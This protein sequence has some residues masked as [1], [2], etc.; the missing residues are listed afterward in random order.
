MDKTLRF[1]RTI[2][3]G[4]VFLLFFQLVADFVETIYTF[5][6]LNTNVPPEIVCVLLFFSPLALLIFRRGLPRGAELGL[7]ALAGLTRAAEV[8]L[9]KSGKMI[10]S[11]LGTGLLLV[12]L[13][14]WLARP[15]AEEGVDDDGAALE[16]GVGVA[17]ALAFSIL[18][19]GLGQG[20]DLSL[21]YPWLSWVEVG[22]LYFLAFRLASR[23]VVA[24]VEPARKEG[25]G[26]FG[27]AAALGVGVLGGLMV[28]FFAFTSPGVLARWSELDNRMILGVLAAA[29]LVYLIALKTGWLA[30]LTRPALWASNLLFVLAGTAGILI[31]QVPFPA[32]SAV[33]PVDQP[34]LILIQQIPL[35]AMIL[36]SPVVLVDLLALAREAKARRFSPRAMA[37]G[38]AIG[39]LFFL[40]IVLAQ[41]F[42]TVYDYIPV[43]GP[44]FRDR[45]WLIFLLAGLGMALPTLLVHRAGVESTSAGWMA[46]V[47]LPLGAAALLGSFAWALMSSTAPLSPPAD[48]G[49]LRV[50]TY[51][52]QQGYSADGKRSYA[53]QVALIRGLEPD[54]VGLE[55]S[56]TARFS[57]GNADV[58]RSI[59]TG[60]RMN[61]YYGPR[62]VTGTFGIALLSHYPI[63]NPRTFYMY[64]AG[65][66]TAAIEAI[67]HTPNGKEFTIVVTHL[68]NDGP[69]IQQEEVLGRLQGKQ[70]IIAMGDFNFDRESPQ[71]RLTRA[72]L[73]DAWITGGSAP[74]EGMEMDRQID[75]IFVSPG[76]TVSAAE[77]VVS[78]ASD[79]PLLWAEI[80]Q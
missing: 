60:L 12:W 52:I 11:G 17:L 33:Y 63:E 16:A 49:A 61:S 24:R 50:I 40:I 41:A 54:V 15:S 29:L 4:L 73:E 43:V 74:V 70:N 59:A 7:V 51:N 31:N 6:L 27:A 23:A 44:W 35:L 46:R 22:L 1:S 9:D 19:H 77:Y 3:Y 55:K 56:D 36:L 26:S 39:A 71:Y 25:R 42:T 8:V 80:G 58:V 18:L 66:Q 57:G 30:G 62:T 10:A 75:H 14:S 13:A 65:E 21:I 28:L 64:S 69:I 47:V 67:I 53:D 72:S 34:K 2:L 48:T 5:G 32:Q 45:F 79:H 37:G 20:T 76:T 38:T 78:P 68:G